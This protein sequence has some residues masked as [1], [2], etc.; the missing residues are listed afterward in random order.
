MLFVVFSF[1]QRWHR[2][3]IRRALARDAAA[4]A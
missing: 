2:N 1:I 4:A 3:A